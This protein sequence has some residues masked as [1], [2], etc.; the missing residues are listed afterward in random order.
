MIH[1]ESAPSRDV[2]RAVS[3]SRNARSTY[4]PG[5]DGGRLS[6]SAGDRP[7]RAPLTPAYSTGTGST[8]VG[9]SVS[10]STTEM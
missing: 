3:F 10:S 8:K 2:L 6:E 7:Q 9:S 4:R 5:P 1:D